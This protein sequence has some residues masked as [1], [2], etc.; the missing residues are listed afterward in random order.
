[1]HPAPYPHQDPSTFG[2][3]D[4]TSEAATFSGCSQTNSEAISPVRTPSDKPRLARRMGHWAR[5][6]FAQHVIHL[7]TESDDGAL[8]YI[9]NTFPSISFENAKLWLR[10]LKSL[11]LNGTEAD[12]YIMDTFRQLDWHGILRSGAAHDLVPELQRLMS[13]GAEAPRVP[14]SPN[15]HISEMAA[16]EDEPCARS[17][18]SES[19][20]KGAT[21]AQHSAD[22]PSAK[23]LAN[24]SNAV[25]KLYAQ[26]QDAMTS[27]SLL[28]RDIFGL[29]QQIEGLTRQL[30]EPDEYSGDS[31]NSSQYSLVEPSPLANSSILRPAITIGPLRAF[32]TGKRD[33]H[34]VL[35]EMVASIPGGYRLPV[36]TTVIAMEEYPFVDAFFESVAERNV[37][38]RAFLEHVPGIFHGVTANRVMLRFP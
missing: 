17:T 13:A 32:V 35:Q 16:R 6:A 1:M 9:L 2:G 14:Q 3:D 10:Y 22:E 11:S 21:V 38:H 30:L 18:A 15:A 19:K 20:G 27:W 24:I 25:D 5:N 33:A 29:K 23:T 31:D 26:M 34:S 36:P 7:A 28:A 8:A 37:F 12:P 4:S